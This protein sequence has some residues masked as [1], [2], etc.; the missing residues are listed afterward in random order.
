MDYRTMHPTEQITQIMSRI[1]SRGMTTTSGG[2][3]SYRDERGRI[4]VTP[5]SFDKAELRPE[6]IVCI[7]PDGTMVGANR[8]TSEYKFHM[9]AMQARPE[10]HGVIHAHSIALMGYSFLK[11]APAVVLTTL[12][13]ALATA[14]ALP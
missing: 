12:R 13:I 8:P 3:L 2:N 11:T 6:D 7:Q 5:T 1:Y 14:G 4:W 9:A 10:F